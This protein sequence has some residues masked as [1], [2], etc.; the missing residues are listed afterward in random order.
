MPSYVRASYSIS[1]GDLDPDQVSL[2][3]GL[4]PTSSRKPG[5]VSRVTGH[6][7]PR[8]GYWAVSV[9]RRDQ[10]DLTW[11]LADLIEVL[12]PAW[13]QFVQLGTEAYAV[14]SIAVEA[15]GMM[16]AL[17]IDHPRLRSLADLRADFDLTV[18]LASEA[19]AGPD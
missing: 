8:G 10:E 16:P 4:I 7:Q 14:V 1:A 11:V 13:D 19:F 17:I 5:G 2:R 3:T 15:V 18:D 12:L 6:A 9:E